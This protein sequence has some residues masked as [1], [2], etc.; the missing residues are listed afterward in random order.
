MNLL[1]LIAALSSDATE[2]GDCPVFI[3]TYC[4]A[5]HGCTGAD[6]IPCDYEAPTQVLFHNGEIIINGNS[7]ATDNGMSTEELTARA[8]RA[9]KSLGLP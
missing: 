8:D 2:H 5:F 7:N 4:D 3:P 1:A 9:M 6:D